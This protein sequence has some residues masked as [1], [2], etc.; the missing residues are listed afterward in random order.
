MALRVKLLEGEQELVWAR[1]TDN[2]EAYLKYLKAY[3]TFKS[4]NRQNMILTRQICEEIIALDPT[5]EPAY[6]LKGVSYLID[7]WFGWAESPRFAIE[8]CEK[9]LRMSISLNSQSDFAHANLGHLYLMQ[10]RYDEALEAGKKSL[11]LNP[12]GDFNMVLLAMTLM[13]TGRSEEAIGLYKESWR[14]NPYCPAWYVHAAG[15]A[16]RNLK[17]WGEAIAVCKKA[18]E[19]NP[20]HFPALIV[21]ASVYGMSGRLEEGRAIASKMM[22]I[23]PGFC[24]EKMWL[25]YKNKV[26]AQEIRDA[27]R[28]VGIPDKSP[29]K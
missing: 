18:L 1:G 8:N 23:N 19:K 20:D 22:K 12:N 2:L 9:A 7:L 24:V 3:N 28:K 21:M 17:E 29:K 16:Y 11:D 15:V 6:T 25:P 26:V 4:F 5:C 14:R 27:L 13:Y 10:E